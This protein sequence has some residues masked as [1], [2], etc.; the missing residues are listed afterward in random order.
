VHKLLARQLRSAAGKEGGPIDFGSLLAI[1]NQTYEAFDRE[2]RLNDRAATLMEGELKAATAQAKREHDSVLAAILAN[3]SDGMIAVADD[4]RIEIANAAAER[5]FAAGPGALEGQDI[6]KLLGE[7]ARELHV[8]QP[9]PNERPELFGTALDGRVFPI[10]YS[11]APLEVSGGR[12]HL[13][14]LRDISERVCAERKVMESQV[15][16]QDFA[17]A[18][19]DCFWEMDGN[20]THVLVSSAQETP[21]SAHLK[22]LLAPEAAAVKPEGLPEEGWRA[23]RHHLVARQR[24]RLRLDFQEGEGES[25]HISVSAKPV[26][27]FDGGFQGYRGTGRDV[28]REVTA[29][30]AARRAERRLIEAM[31]GAP[32]AVALIDSHLNLA[33]SNS[34]L[35]ALAASAGERLSTGRPFSSF[36]DAVLRG[37][38]IVHGANAGAFLRELAESRELREVAIGKS[39][40]LMAARALSEGGM[41][42]NFSDVTALKQRESELAGAKGAAESANQL[43]SQ[44]LTTMSHELRTPLNAI[45]GFSE[46]IRD[47]V[48]GQT[49]NAWLKYAEYASAIHTSGKHLLSLISEILDLSKIEAGSY[50]LDISTMD[51]REIINGALTIISPAA[52]KAGVEIRCPIPAAPLWLSAD[53]RALRQIVLNIFANAVK[54]T[55]KGG[56]ITVDMNSR[57]SMI[58]LAIADTGIG[59]AKEHIDTVFELFRQVDSSMSRRHE[60]TGL[61]LAITKRLVEMHGGKIELES[62]I[63][64]GTTVRVK[65]PA[66]AA[67]AEPQNKASR[68]A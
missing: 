39:W 66:A 20:L 18:S 58:E 35:K 8:P 25:F 47:G 42:L 68:A 10:E 19:S 38:G 3:A 7:A 36:L 61:G 43:K 1:L 17:E 64:V 31:D 45:L 46:V 33:A 51:L 4:G 30:V 24:F 5:Q 63:A 52:L 49:E 54:F 41:V 26:F 15:R 28:T 50:V 53:E 11:V 29:R 34:A 27:D 12:R 2:R 59:I 40:Y 65:M 14:I 57:D 21:V 13:W 37:Q 60:G 48:F 16:F 67:A 6:A 55:P 23:L 56:R 62:E 22:A 44:F 32:S 9:A